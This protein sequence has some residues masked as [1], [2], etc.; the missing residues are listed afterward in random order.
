M[1]LL[2]LDKS[3]TAISVIDLYESLLWTDRYDEY[4]DF[5]LY[6]PADEGIL[7]TIKQ[8]YYLQSGES[9]HLMIVEKK[10]VK[11][12]IEDG[13]HYTVSGRSLESIL[14][15]RII[16]GLKVVKGNFQNAIKEL[17]NENVIAPADA[18][19]KIPNFIFAESTDPAITALTIEAQYTGDNLYDV[20]SKS[21]NE[22]EVGFKVTLNEQNQFVF[23]LYAGQDRSY[24]QTTNPYVVFS[25]N[26]ENLSNSN[27][28][29]SKQALKNVTL[30]GGEGEGAERKYAV[31]GEGVGLERRELFTDARD[32]SSDMGD[33]VVLT[34]AEYTA[35]LQQRGKEK[36]TEC[37][38][39][40][41]FEGEAEVSKMFQYRKD[42]F[43][44]DIVQIANEYGNEGRARVVE[45]VISEDKSGF[46]VYPTF[47]ALEDK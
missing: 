1:D 44:G 15:R 14:E 47:K 9:E 37:V 45:M 13:S 38:E 36:L 43:D 19:R 17:L 35:Q 41:S 34:E 46:S 3:F 25:P 16:W 11:S 23:A 29:E 4:G 31:A 27:Y 30:I 28:M 10:L 33:G 5:E 2:L 24:N 42:F 20:I 32:I 21:C 39:V 6:M 18:N 40:T 12:D 8:D 22:R 26:F 7:N